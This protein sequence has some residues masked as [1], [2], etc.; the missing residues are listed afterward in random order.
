MELVSAYRAKR[1]KRQKAATR[2]LELLFNTGLSQ[3]C[4]CR[5][6][7]QN[8]LVHRKT[9]LRDWAVPDFMVSFTRSLE[10]APM[11]TEDIF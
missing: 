4:V 8:F 3:N 6:S 10:V 11:T 7:G 9:P 2:K 5:V 1:R